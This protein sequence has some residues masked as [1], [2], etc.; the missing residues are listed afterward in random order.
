MK[1]M[2]YERYGGPENLHLQELDIPAPGVDEV[3][4]KIHAASINFGDYALLTGQPFITRLWNGLLKPHRQIL[5]TDISGEVMECG[6]NCHEFHPGEQIVAFTGS[7]GSGAFVEYITL[8]E[9]M[10]AH[11][12]YSLSYDEAATLPQAAVVALQGLRDAGRLQKGEDVLINGASG[13]IG[14]FAVQIAKLFGARVFAVCSSD[15]FELMTSLGVDKVIDYR[16]TDILGLD[17]KYD[18]I[19]DIVSNKT[20]L[21]IIELLNPQGRY[22]ACAFNPSMLKLRPLTVRKQGL[23]V[24]SLIHRPNIRDLRYICDLAAGRKINPVIFKTYALEDLPLAMRELKA[25]GRFG[26]IVISMVKENIIN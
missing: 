13:G 7:K 3:L 5:G 15:H 9:E 20:V 10:I 16:V 23:Q 22:V 12:P 2:V 19:L 1:G 24:Q 26:K 4:I 8:K 21:E 6:R 17:Q 14:T 11:K 18:V 25:K